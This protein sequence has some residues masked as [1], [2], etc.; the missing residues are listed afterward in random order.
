VF[1]MP[2]A[3]TCRRR[4]TAIAALLALPVTSANGEYKVGDVITLYANK[5]GPFANPSEVY[6]FYNLPYCPPEGD[7]E[8][9]RED[10]GPLLKGDRP[11]KTLYAIKFRGARLMQSS[12]SGA[13]DLVAGRLPHV[14]AREAAVDAALQKAHDGFRGQQVPPGY[15][16]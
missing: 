14:C 15:Y 9:K 11:T 1:A 4:F 6:A 13:R 3:A 12:E 2:A 7:F 10:L 16:G 8:V 5:V